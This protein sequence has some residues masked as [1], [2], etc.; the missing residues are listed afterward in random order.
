MDEEATRVDDDGDSSMILS[1]S[2]NPINLPQ[3]QQQHSSSAAAVSGTTLFQAEVSRPLELIAAFCD[4][5]TLV[6]LFRVSKSVH[7]VATSDAVWRPILIWLNL[8]PLIVGYDITEQFYHFFLHSIVTTTAL[9]GH[10]TFQAMDSS[11]SNSNGR[12]ASRGA[13][14]SASSSPKSGALM[15]DDVYHVASLQTLISAASL[16]QKN[17]SIGRVQILLT[18]KNESMEVLQ[19]SCRFSVLRRCFSLC[20]SSFGTTKRGPV[21]TVAI[22]TMTK[23]WANE[24]MQH[25]LSHKD[26]LRL[27]MAPVLWEGQSAES[28]ITERDILVASR[29]KPTRVVSGDETTSLLETREKRK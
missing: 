20:C 17:H 4:L 27:I 28:Q 1:A 19:G 5:S 9:H 15:D 16:G 22:A 29:P 7:T 6:E 3:Q 11:S 26:G 8:H 10:Y 13:W 2:D 12:G 18:F 21:F 24:S 23:P 14:A 25:F